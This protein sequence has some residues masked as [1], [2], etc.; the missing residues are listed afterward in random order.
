[1]SGLSTSVVWFCVDSYQ[2]SGSLRID[3]GSAKGGRS[4][5]K[6][7]MRPSEG[8]DERP[9]IGKTSNFLSQADTKIFGIHVSLI[10]VLLRF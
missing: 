1:M 3:Q 7:S 4:T 2:L 10:N 9:K 5:P 6:G 8:V